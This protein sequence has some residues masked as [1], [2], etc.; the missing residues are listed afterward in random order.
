MPIHGYSGGGVHLDASA[1][2]NSQAHLDQLLREGGLAYVNKVLKW[3]EPWAPTADGLKVANGVKNATVA[4]YDKIRQR[5]LSR[6]TTLNAAQ[7]A[8]NVA[9]NTLTQRQQ[10][11]AAPLNEKNAAERQ[12][13]AARTEKQRQYDIEN[14]RKA[15]ETARNKALAVSTGTI[16]I[17]AKG[18]YLYAQAVEEVNHFED[19][20]KKCNK[21]TL[22]ITKKEVK[23]TRHD[24]TNKVT[25]FTAGGNINLLS[26]DDST[27]EASKIAAGNN[28]HLTSTQGTVNFR[29]VKNTTFE[30]TVSLSKGFYIKQSDKGY[31]RQVGHAQH[32]YGRKPESRCSSRYQC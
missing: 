18:G 6:Q 19:K 7:N 11:L 13:N 9:Q 31:R 17:A 10:Q 12:L 15:Q 8:V 2:I 21:W 30:Q 16:D 24:V 14:Q 3:G 5:L 29:A 26:R 1:T 23:Q 25:N 4:E 27:Y 20:E 22:C 32:S 28:A